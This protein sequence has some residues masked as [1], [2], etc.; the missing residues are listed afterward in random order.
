MRELG[1]RPL[2]ARRRGAVRL[3]VPVD[4]RARRS[5]RRDV[6]PQH[7][8]ALL[9]RARAS[10]STSCPISGAVEV[11]PRLGVAE[12]IVD[13]V[14]T[15]STLVMNGLRP[16]GDILASEAVLVANPTPAS[17]TRAAELDGIVTMLGAVIAARGRK[18][19]MMN[20][21]ADEARGARGPAARARV[22]VG[23]PAGARRDDRDPRGR[24]RRRGLG[25]A[26]ARSRRPGRPGSSCCRSR[27]SSRD[28]H[29]ASTPSCGSGGS[30][31]GRPIAAAVRRA[32]RAVP[33]RRRARSRPSARRRARIL[34]DVRAGGA[35][36]VR[37]AAARFG[38]GRPDG[39]LLLTRAELAAAADA[40]PAALRVGARGGDRQRPPVRRDP[41]ARLA[42]HDDR[43]GRRARAPLAAG[44]GA[45]AAYVPGGSAPYPS[46]LV[47]TVVPAQV[48]GVAAHRRRLARRSRRRRSTRSCSAR[49]GC[50]ASTA[51]LV[52]GGAQAIGALAFGLA[53]RG[54]RRRPI[55]SSARGARGSPPPSS[56]SPGRSPSTCRPVRRRAS[57]S[58]TRRPTRRPSPPTSS[59]R[60]STAPTPRPSS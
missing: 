60:P 49:P 11:A 43:P 48:A 22:A 26:P 36:A 16:I 34:A 6:A 59:R 56:S 51:L 33:A 3:P 21:P 17:Q 58:P 39:R 35:V 41:A 42:A 47:M 19:L 27:R 8:A 28:R 32:R 7:R 9:R 53:G 14:S 37:D 44:L 52:A 2:P 57:C 15:G 38:G 12:A 54:P 1:L 55:S 50:S 29:G 5:P 23:D 40:L 24:R 18:Y 45:S 13:L 30:T 46:S 25:P 4:R 31:S 10:P 20:A